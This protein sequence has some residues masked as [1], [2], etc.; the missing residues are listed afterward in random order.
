[1]RIDSHQHFRKVSR[2]D[3][4]WMKLEMKILVRDYLP[5]DLEP[6]LEKHQIGKTVAVQAAPTMAE[7]DFLLGRRLRI[8]SQR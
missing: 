6:S 7:T 2:G 3:Y 4:S 8:A 5:E 1:M